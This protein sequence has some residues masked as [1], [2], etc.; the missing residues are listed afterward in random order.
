MADDKHIDRDKALAIIRT[1]TEAMKPGTQKDALQSVSE[2][3]ESIHDD[4]TK[5]TREEREAKIIELLT[6]MRNRMGIEERRE[7]AAFYLD[8]IITK[9]EFDGMNEKEQADFLRGGGLVD[10]KEPEAA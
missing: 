5:M 6:S 9:K 4:V 3:I 10:M 2:W 8:S 7:H 1:I